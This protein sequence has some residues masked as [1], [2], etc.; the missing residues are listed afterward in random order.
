MSKLEKTTMVETAQ[1]EKFPNCLIVIPLYNHRNTLAHVLQ[2]VC[3]ALQGCGLPANILVVDDGSTD[4]G[5]DGVPL[6]PAPGGK[7]CFLRHPKNLGKG[8]AILSAAAWAEQNGYSHIITLDSDGQHLPEDIPAFFA[9]IADAPHK[10]FI[11]ARDF[12]T[13]NVPFSSRFGRSFSGFWMRVQT[14]VGVA[15]MQSGFRAYPVKI[16]PALTLFEKRYSFEIEVLVK[17]AWAGFEIA[18]LP[19]KVFYPPAAERVSHFKSAADNIRISILNT[20]LTIRALIPVPFRRYTEAEGGKISVLRPLQ[21][22]RLLLCEQ[23]T[24]RV[25]ALSTIFSVFV[26]ALPLIGLQSI[27]ILLGI[28]YLRLNRLWALAVSHLCW[29]PL[30]PALCIEAGYFL[31]HGTFLT[32]ISLQTLGY[33]I[34]QRFYE[35]FL[36]ALVLGPLA[37][38]L[39][40]GLVYLTAAVIQRGLN[41]RHP[42]RQLADKASIEVESF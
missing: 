39:L 28:G 10:I 21:S 31:R 40:G 9:A 18:C 32:D 5:Y 37:A 2:G 16:F 3:N 24:P 23:S 41:A 34:G 35:W 19:I 20:R 17:A 29:P 27:V 36:G 14:G 42:A 7:I 11:G 6:P 22:L 25:L 1:P 13:P 33:E 30:V 26:C 12:N 38:L 15:D 4:G 8:A